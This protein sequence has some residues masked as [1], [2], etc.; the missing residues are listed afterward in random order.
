[1]EG[2][3]CFNAGACNTNGLVLPALEYDHGVGCSITGG[4]VYRGSAV[5][6]ARGHYFYSDYCSGFLRSFV[7]ANGVATDA[8]EWE[9]GDLG[10]VLS[11][12]EDSAGEGYV[13]SQN[14]NVYRL[15]AN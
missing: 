13:L 1:M 7:Y 8:R 5:P 11:F 4:H 15:I 14:G 3:H 9:V 6:A 10:R 2:Q 12:G